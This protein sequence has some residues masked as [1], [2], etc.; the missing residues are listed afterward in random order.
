SD[1]VDLPS[2]IDFVKLRGAWARTGSDSDISP[3]A[4]S[5]TYRFG[6]QID[7]NALAYINESTIPN[8]NLKPATSNSYEAGF[9]LNF[10][11]NRLGIYFTWYNR[12]T[13]N[14]ILSSEVSITSGFN[15]VRINSGVMQNKGVEL[16]LNTVPIR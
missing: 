14:D 8:T 13:I 10:L 9:D 6:Q 4:Q 15:N 12:K 7:G 2:G 16:L 11:K 3:Y 1:V 5:L